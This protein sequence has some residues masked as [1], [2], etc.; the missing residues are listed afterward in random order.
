MKSKLM[1]CVLCFVLK[2]AV[3]S[4]EYEED[5]GNQTETYNFTTPFP[6]IFLTEVHYGGVNHLNESMNLTTL[7]D[8]LEYDPVYYN[9]DIFEKTLSGIMNSLQ[10]DIVS[11]QRRYCPFIP[12]CNVS[13]LAEIS[14]PILF[15][16]CCTTCSCDLENCHKTRTCCPDILDPWYF[17]AGEHRD[18][19]SSSNPKTKANIPHDCISLYLRE[20]AENYVFAVAECPVNSEHDGEK[21]SREYNASTPMQD[22]IPVYSRITYRV[23]RNRFCAYCNGYMEDE[24]NYLQ[25]SLKCQ[26]FQNINEILISGEIV[27]YVYAHQNCNIVFSTPD[28][29]PDFLEYCSYAINK[30]NSTGQWNT[31]SKEIETAC[32]SYRSLV[33][34][35]G[36]KYQNIFC[37]VCNGLDASNFDVECPFFR[38]N[39]VNIP[40]S[41]SGLLKI[42]KTR[43][44]MRT[45]EV[46]PGNGIYYTEKVNL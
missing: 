31:G 21:C 25:A 10:R 9:K 6:F 14:D 35:M 3:V 18:N 11:I 41:F 17:N 29:A 40:F 16:S 43:E 20:P 28:E 32:K 34:Y 24:I 4:F 7:G 36:S 30:C 37:L 2:T 39:D 15:K 12:L 46:C 26:G 33:T 19:D 38:D 23:F 45:G 44:P 27:E 8:L 42:E 5:W 1:Y 22:R 13:K